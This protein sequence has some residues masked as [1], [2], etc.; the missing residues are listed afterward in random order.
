MELGQFPLMQRVIHDIHNPRVTCAIMLDVYEACLTF[1]H[2]AP[3][4]QT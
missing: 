2:N 4:S 1:H 3:W